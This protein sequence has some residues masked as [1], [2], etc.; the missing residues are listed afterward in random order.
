MF[1]EGSKNKRAVLLATQIYLMEKFSWDYNTL[2][3]QPSWLIENIVSYID[4]EA[5]HNKKN[6]EQ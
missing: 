3:K 1:L 6:V 2:M 5:Q 4:L